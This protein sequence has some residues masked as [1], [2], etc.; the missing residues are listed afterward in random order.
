MSKGWLTPWML[1]RIFAY[2][3]LGFAIGCFLKSC[4]YLEWCH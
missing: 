1:G 3:V 2:E 4:V